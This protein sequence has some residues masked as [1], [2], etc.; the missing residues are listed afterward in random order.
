[1]FHV[2]R[3]EQPIIS[4]STGERVSRLSHQRGTFEA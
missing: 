1:L 4:D 3:S 2:K